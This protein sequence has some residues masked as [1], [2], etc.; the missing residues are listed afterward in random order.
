M[1]LERDISSDLMRTSDIL[2]Q[3]L[4][5]CLCENGHCHCWMSWHIAFSHGLQNSQRIYSP[6]FGFIIMVKRLNGVQYWIKWLVHFSPVH[7]RFTS[8]VHEGNAKN[9]FCLKQ[10]LTQTV[11]CESRAVVLNEYGSSDAGTLGRWDAGTLG[12]WLWWNYQHY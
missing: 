4:T 5:A 9:R 3:L 2:T 7:F 12:C 6:Q 10:V 11:P 1:L 8:L